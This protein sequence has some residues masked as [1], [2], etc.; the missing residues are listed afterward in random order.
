MGK[1]MLVFI[2]TSGWNYPHWRGVFYPQRL[3]S[4]EWL[5]YYASYFNTV[6]VNAT[7][8]GTPKEKTIRRW[9]TSVP[10]QFI[11]ALKAHR[12]ITHVRRL[13]KVK[14][15][16]RRLYALVELFG[17][18]AGPLLFQLP[19]TLRFD[20]SLIEDFIALLDLRFPT[21]IEVRHISFHDERF[22]ALLRKARIALCISD[23]AGK[24]PSL[25]E[26]ITAHFVYIRLHGSPELYQSPYHTEELR[27]WAQKI[28]RW[29]RPAYVYFD[30]DALGWAPLNALEL[31]QLLGQKTKPLPAPLGPLSEKEIQD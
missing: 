9:C 8:Y 27:I 22:F 21:A 31:K 23:T 25:I 18:K 5:S 26:E 6:E 15:P 7:F 12:F 19:P 30:N 16:L 11:F 4:R 10:D 29:Q 1:Q 20:P 2:G 14:E 28:L 24:Y 3:A 17:P 13:R